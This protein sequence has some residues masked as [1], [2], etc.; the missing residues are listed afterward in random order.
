ME[1][2]SMKMVNIEYILD[3][4]LKKNKIARDRVEVEKTH[5]NFDFNLAN[6]LIG[7]A[8]KR[9]QP[10]NQEDIDW[11]IN[12]IKCKYNVIVA[13]YALCETS[14]EIERADLTIKILGRLP[15]KRFSKKLPDD[16][17]STLRSIMEEVQKKLQPEISKGS[18]DKILIRKK[19]IHASNLL[20]KLLREHGVEED[21]ITWDDCIVDQ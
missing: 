19:V 1:S 20:A 15:E 14:E 10:L 2:K 17:N 12:M 4:V 13:F 5:E 6:K 3:E 11:V 16:V 9:R 21:V 8:E 7:V 18:D